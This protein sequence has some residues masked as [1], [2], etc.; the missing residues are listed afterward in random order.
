MRKL[1]IGSLKHVARALGYG[2]LGAFAALLVGFV[3]HLNNQPDLFVWH[4]V[5]LDAEF[6]RDSD[7]D[8]FEDY[9]ALEERLFRQL[10]ELVYEKVPAKQQTHFNRYAS[11]SRS[12]PGIWDR[13]WNR[14]FVLEHARPKAG[15]LLIHGLSDSPY[16]IRSAAM[17]L[18]R[19]GAYA[20]GMRVPGHGT[21]PSGLVR[22]TWEDMAAALRLG[23]R[24][25][26]QKIGDRP[27]YIVG[28]SNG[29][30]L[31]VHYALM[32]LEDRSLPRPDGLVL[33]S[34]MIGVSPAAALAIWQERIGRLLG[35]EKLQWNSVLQEI[36]PYK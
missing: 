10:D 27:L 19:A 33:L 34:P 31:A 11:G 4:T 7:V 15:V 8:S 16:S 20:V 14:S 26:R 17:R 1:V 3:V 35:L 6:T 18:H 29:G 25:V 32:A 2:A 30:T 13:N 36:D 22:V 21:A 5:E 23:V 28:Y 9:L 12:D 24:H